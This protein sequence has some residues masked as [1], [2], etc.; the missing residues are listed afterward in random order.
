MLFFLRFTQKEAKMAD[1]C[2]GKTV[3]YALVTY[4]HVADYG[5]RVGA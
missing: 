4:R 3:A 5:V 2:V 1:F